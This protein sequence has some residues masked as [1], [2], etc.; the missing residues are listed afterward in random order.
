MEV[1]NNIFITSQNRI[2][3]IFHS[4]YN[5]LVSSD[6]IHKVL[7]T[8]ITR[9]LLMALGMVTSI[10]VARILGPE[11][12]G[13]YAVAF[14]IGTIGVQFGNL[15]LHSSNTYYVAKDRKLLPQLVGNTLVVSFVF[16]GLIIALSGII[17]SLWPNLA[18]I[19]GILLMMAILWIPFGLA[20][21]LLQNILLG[22]MEIKTFNIIELT[23]RILTVFLILAPFL[24]TFFKFIS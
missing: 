21:M 2:W 24:F 23:I 4:L 5:R 8:F 15:G 1:K 3:Q 19:H 6:F 17:F 11:G 20:Y 9:I 16:G 10:I 18:P 14:A 13:L 12:R 22:I 7:G